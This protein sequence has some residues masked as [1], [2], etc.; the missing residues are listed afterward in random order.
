MSRWDGNIWYDNPHT[1]PSMLTG[2]VRIVF[3][4][5][6]VALFFRCMSAL[7]GPANTMKSGI[8]CA[9]VA[10][11]VA[12]FSFLTIPI[13]IDMY[14]LFLEY[15]SNR[16]F[17]GGDEYF[18]GPLGYDVFLTTKPLATFFDVMFPLNQWLADGL[19]VSAV[20]KSAADVFNI[21]RSCSCTVAMSS[22]P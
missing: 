9:L 13:L 10:H 3:L 11:T 20:S 19:L 1:R 4:G 14:Y 6:A 22:I 7:L 15:I 5:I 16:E 18:P 2:P 21:G 12:L 17:T 8:R